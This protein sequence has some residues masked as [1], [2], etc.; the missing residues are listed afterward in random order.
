MIRLFPGTDFHIPIALDAARHLVRLLKRYNWTMSE[1]KRHRDRWRRFWRGIRPVERVIVSMY[2]QCN[3]GGLF[4]YRIADLSN[5]PS[6]LNSSDSRSQRYQVD[7]GTLREFARLEKIFVRMCV[8]VNL[9]ALRWHATQHDEFA[10][11]E[12]ELIM[13]ASRWLGSDGDVSLDAEL[14]EQ[15][16]SVGLTDDVAYQAAMRLSREV[17]CLLNERKQASFEK[18]HNDDAP[19]RNYIATPPLHDGLTTQ[20][21]LAEGRLGQR[22]YRDGVL[23]LWNNACAVTGC[24]L[25]AV[26]V[27]SHAKPWAF[28]TDSERLNPNNGLPLVG[29]LDRL[30]DAGLIGFDPGTGAMHVSAAV[31]MHHQALLGIPAPLRRKPSG[32]QAT[33]LRYHLEHVFRRQS[34]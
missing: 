28:S 31:E 18:T 29:T 24:S 4:R 12:S 19:D 33:F 14:Y 7:D 3:N 6:T 1:P 21:R 26:V 8:D 22:K 34:E 27:A 11:W 20:E 32:A 15:L 25:S 2:L 5:L 9:I 13:G 17:K 10:L 23:A 30:F 16:K